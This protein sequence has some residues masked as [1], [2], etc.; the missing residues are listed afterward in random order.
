MDRAKFFDNIR[1]SLFGGKLSKAQ[2]AGLEAILEAWRVLFFK[3]ERWLAYILAT[4][5]HE[6]NRTMRA[7]EE[8]GKGRGK[9]YGKPDKETGKTYFGRGLVQL[10]WKRN[11]CAAS[12]FLYQDIDLASHPERALELPVAA[13]II[14]C[15]MLDGTFAGH[16]LEDFFSEATE[17][18]R[19]ARRIVN[20][21][22]CADK[23][24]GYGKKFYA[25]L[26][27]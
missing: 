14:V 25:A 17:D 24:A 13:Q 4:A 12:E 10:T 7:I 5:Y 27:A 11:Y 21:L 18:W 16:K 23:I 8:Y 1:D 19:G 15:G 6:T 9:E 2:V 22:D 3:D 20:G 26:R